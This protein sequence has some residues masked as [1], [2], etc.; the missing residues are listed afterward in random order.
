[1]HACVEEYH[2]KQSMPAQCTCMRIP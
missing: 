1:M 2:I